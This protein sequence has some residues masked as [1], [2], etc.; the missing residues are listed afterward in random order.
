MSHTLTGPAQAVTFRPV[1]EVAR[2]AEDTSSALEIETTEEHRWLHWLVP[3][4]V[5]GAAFF[6]LAIG[7]GW[8]YFMAP[9]MALGIAPIIFA[10]VYLGLSSD[11]EKTQS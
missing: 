6:A 10:F 8:E 2:P 1:I 3:P 4:F 11:T 5:L 9:A 7:T